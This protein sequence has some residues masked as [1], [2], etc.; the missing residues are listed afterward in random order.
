ML[1]LYIILG[2]LL[3]LF[4]ITLF[5][6]YVYADYDNELFLNLKIA[7]IKIKLIPSKPKKKK[8]EK[9][10]KKKK[11]DSEKSDKEKKKKEKSFSIKDYVKQKGVSGIINIVKRISALAVD[12]LKDLFSKITV[13]ELTVNIKIAAETAEETAVNYG[14]VCAVFFPALKLITDIVTVKRYNVNVNP[15]FTDGAKSSATAKVIAKI[16]ILSLL[17]IAVTRAFTALRIYLRA[18]PKKKKQHLKN[19]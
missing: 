8:P 16:R 9:K 7:F 6:I 18:K 15:D 17:K 13:N 4:L 1:A 11:L 12:T 5:N 19:R 10:K 14:R 3:F 2:I